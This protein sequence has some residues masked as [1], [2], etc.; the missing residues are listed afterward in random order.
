MA[1]SDVATKP[2]KKVVE[3][4]YVTGF[5]G[6]GNHEGSQNKSPSG[7]IMKACPLG[8]VI[9]AD[10]IGELV[11]TCECHDLS[12]Q[13]ESL[14][15]IQLPRPI[16]N[17]QTPSLDRLLRETAV[18][19]GGAKAPGIGDPNRPTVA[20]ASGARFAVTPTGRAARG[21]LEEQVRHVLC[22]QIK[23]AGV[24]MIA[25]LGLTPSTISLAIDK[26]NPP[27]TGAIYSVLK[28]WEGAVLVELAEGPF[29][30]IKFTD[31]GTRELVR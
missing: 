29:R 4:F 17:R 16:I 9:L 22:T 23:A 18:G 25:A 13:M 15:G 21:Q 11:C 28:R 2:G 27:S 20:V 6:I 1:M 12:R 19:T 3:S 5:C 8:G 31:R 7:A 24:D 30:F 26:E 14:T 10:R